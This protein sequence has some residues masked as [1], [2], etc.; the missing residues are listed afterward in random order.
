METPNNRG[1]KIQNTHSVN[2]N[3]SYQYT[4][5]TPTPETGGTNKLSNSGF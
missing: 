2:F 1:N 5:E 4:L 3:A